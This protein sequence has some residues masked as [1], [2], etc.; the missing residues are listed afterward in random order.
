MKIGTDLDE[1]LAEFV[2]SFLNWHNDKY[3]TNF[4]RE[5]IKSFNLWETIGGTREDAINKVYDF[6]KTKYFKELPVTFGSQH[7]LRTLSRKNDIFLISSR[8]YCVRDETRKWLDQH[9]NDIF[10]DV[11]L[12][13]EWARYSFAT[14]FKR[15]IK[16]FG[17]GSTKANICK[18]LCLDF[19]VEDNLDYARDCARN[20]TKVFL[21]DRPWNRGG[22]LLYGIDRVYN[23]N[24]IFEKIENGN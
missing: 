18:K 12:T 14:F 17:D 4:D 1:C 19:Y 5:D 11:I 9:F 6:Y 10:D 3:K 13:D 16:L 2:Y 21:L 8:P 24:E 22:E 20:G 15:F 7:V 23:W